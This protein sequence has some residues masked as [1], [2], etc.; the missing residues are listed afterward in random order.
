MR[1]RNASLALIIALTTATSLLPG[2]AVADVTVLQWDSPV[3]YQYQVNWMP[4]LDQRRFGMLDNGSAHCVPTSHMNMLAYAANF[5]F[6]NLSP[7]PGTWTNP[8]VH[9]VMTSR[10]QFLGSVMG[11]TGGGTSGVGAEQ[12]MSLWIEDYALSYDR[13]YF[14]EEGGGLTISG[15]VQDL[16][17]GHI[18][19]LCYGRYQ[20]TPATANVAR[21]GE[22]TGGHCVTLARATANGFGTE[23]LWVCDPADD[24]SPFDVNTQSAY[25]FRQFD[26]EVT[27]LLQH[28]LNGDDFFVPFTGVTLDWNGFSTPLRLMDGYS[29]LRP[30]EGLF[31]NNVV[32]AVE[33]LVQ[34]DWLAYAPPTSP[35]P[36][37]GTNIVSVSP[38]VGFNDFLIASNVGTQSAELVVWN[39]YEQVQDDA[40]RLSFSIVDTHVDPDGAIVMA[41]PHRIERRRHDE[42][43]SPGSIAWI[44][45]TLDAMIGD[46][47]RRAIW[48][49]TSDSQSLIRLDGRAPSDD[50]LEYIPVP[51]W[52]PA[53]PM[54]DLDVC[55]VTGHLW[56]I[57]EGSDKIYRIS[58]DDDNVASA[59]SWTDH[60]VNDPA[61]ISCDG[62]G[63]VVVSDGTDL[64]VFRKQADGNYRVVNDPRYATLSGSGKFLADHG[65]TNYDPEIHSA[66][67]WNTNIPAED[68]A[69]A[70][71]FLACPAD[72]DGDRVVGLREL[73]RVLAKLGSDDPIADIVPFGGDGIVGIRDLVAVLL[74]WGSCD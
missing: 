56:A 15:L 54:V 60:N 72:F 58:V 41:G 27:S 22:R 47:D 10:I 62:Q 63:Q 30:T 9:N 64:Q 69:P 20:W 51:S 42:Y 23:E 74:S 61:S 35:E 49:Y 37:T 50:D 18:A 26:V 66:I 34:G 31:Y 53:T 57:F 5:G 33:G 67:G 52:M 46:D 29:I 39:Q 55:P 16:A 40:I 17:G 11:T 1:R 59:A 12:G 8:S 38:F 25:R 43:N 65:R 4:D 70:N 3:N 68:L 2:R 48:A 19:T 73:R 13:K 24:R 44:S 36:Y 7:F 6:P 32:V 71:S 28:D 21:L 45:D 14:T